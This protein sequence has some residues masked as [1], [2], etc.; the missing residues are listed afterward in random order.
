MVVNECAFLF[1]AVLGHSY[2][3]KITAHHGGLQLTLEDILIQHH[4][5]SPARVSW[6]Y[7]DYNS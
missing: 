2:V 1:G 5:S 4:Y 6:I 3:P 7:Y